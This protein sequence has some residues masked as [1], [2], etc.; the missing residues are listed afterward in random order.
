M[1]EV[2]GR[3]ETEALVEW[4]CALTWMHDQ[5]PR[6]AGPRAGDDRFDKRSSDALVA[7]GFDDEH[8]LDVAG[9]APDITRLWNPIEHGQPC[10]TDGMTI[11]LRDVRDVALLT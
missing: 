6:A 1:Q 8:A 10:H 2:L 4:V 5:V 7:E 9:E 11:A 3:G